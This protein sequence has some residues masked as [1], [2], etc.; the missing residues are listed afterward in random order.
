[1]QT[2]VYVRVA[3][4]PDAPV[5]GKGGCV[6][7]KDVQSRVADPHRKGQPF[8]VFV[9]VFLALKDSFSMTVFFSPPIFQKCYRLGLCWRKKKTQRRCGQMLAHK[10][11]QAELQHVVCCGCTVAT[12]LVHARQEGQ[13]EDRRSSDYINQMTSATSSDARGGG[14]GGGGKYSRTYP[15]PRTLLAC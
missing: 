6:G 10:Q 1:M 8:F 9:F 14:E 4:W 3:S 12:Y 15:N 11:Q 5:S 2:F 7:P 13:H